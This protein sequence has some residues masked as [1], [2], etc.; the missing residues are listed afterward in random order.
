QYGAFFSVTADLATATA[1]ADTT[2]DVILRL[3]LKHGRAVEDY[4]CFPDTQ[5]VVASARARFV[6]ASGPRVEGPYGILQPGEGAEVDPLGLDLIVVP[7]VAVDRHGNRV[8]HGA[9]FYD[10]TFA[11]RA[12]RPPPPVL[13]GVCHGFQVV[14]ALSAQPWDVPVD[15]VVTDAGIL[16]P[17]MAHRGAGMGED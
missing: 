4:S 16:R 5:E 1:V 10:R 3:R 13:L 6:V 9:G 14:E 2:T 12:D 7:L 11:A 8:G 15:L 17:G